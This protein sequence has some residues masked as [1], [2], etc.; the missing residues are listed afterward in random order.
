[1]MMIMS[2]MMMMMV[3]ISMWIILFIIIIQNIMMLM[4][5]ACQLGRWTRYC[6]VTSAEN[7]N[8]CV[9]IKYK[10]ITYKYKCIKYKYKCTHLI[11]VTFFYTTA[12]L[13][14]GNSTL[15]SAYIRDKTA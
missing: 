4:Q 14:P 10:Y 7:T 3:M 12:I 6:I 15:E 8:T 13:R 5:G 9:Y 2:M 1:M 11:V